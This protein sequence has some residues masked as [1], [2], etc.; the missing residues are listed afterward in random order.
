M[1]KGVVILALIIMLQASIVFAAPVIESFKLQFVFPSQIQVLWKVND[2]IGLKRIELYKDQKL[3]YKEDTKGTREVNLFQLGDDNMTHVYDFYVYNT[4]NESAKISKMGGGDQKPPVI[5]PLTIISN[6]KDVIF[7]TS[8]PATCKAGLTNESLSDID[9]TL[10]IDHNASSFLLNEGSTKVYVVCHDELD[11]YNLI[12]DV[13]DFTF[14]IT[15]PSKVSNVAYADNRI[16]WTSATDSNGILNYKIY[17]SLK[18]IETTTNNYWDVSTNDSIYYISAIDNAGNEGDKEEFN[19]GREIL[20]KSTPK[21]NTTEKPVVNKNE[22]GGAGNIST[23]SIIAWT[24]FGVL[25]LIFIGW[26]IYEHKTD[27]HGLR[28]YLKERRKMRESN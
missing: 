12:P 10:Q 19:V 3:I 22:T 13:I 14:D 17:N 25:L 28:R 2:S 1:R 6:N 20:L 26:K 16:T 23:T 18:N 27:R 7:N 5:S 8:E 21:P 24:I 11:N 15:K 9:K 4:L